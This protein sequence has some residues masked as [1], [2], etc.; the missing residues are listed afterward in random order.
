MKLSTALINTLNNQAENAHPTWRKIGQLAIFLKL[1]KMNQTVNI[2]FSLLFSLT[3]TIS[4][5]R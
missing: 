5:E 4:F 3:F 1:I 2:L